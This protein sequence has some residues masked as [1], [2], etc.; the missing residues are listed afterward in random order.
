[1]AAEEY[2]KRREGDRD[3]LEAM[4]RY[5]RSTRC[6]VK[7]LLDYFGEK[8]VPLC[9]R[10]DNCKKYGADAD[11]ERLE[12]IGSPLRD[13]EIADD[14]GDDRPEVPAFPEAPPPPRKDPTHHF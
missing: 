3:K 11:Q 8:G 7:I 13:L 1:R 4:L 6:R 10:C 2:R 14:D 12:D 9:G 5:A